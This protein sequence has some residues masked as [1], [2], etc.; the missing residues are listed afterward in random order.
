MVL[1]RASPPIRTRAPGNATPTA[2]PYPGPEATP[3]RW[4]PRL[5]GSGPSA[6]RPPTI[7]LRPSYT[8]S[9]AGTPRPPGRPPAAPGAGRTTPAARRR[10]RRGHCHSPWR[11]AMQ[12]WQQRTALRSSFLRRSRWTSRPGK[13]RRGPRGR[14]RSYAGFVVLALVSPVAMGYVYLLRRQSR[15]RSPDSP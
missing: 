4:P 1:D 12:T 9:I 3:L 2:G 11:G 5:R 15:A 7:T 14:Q 8:P 6:L 10:C 13:P